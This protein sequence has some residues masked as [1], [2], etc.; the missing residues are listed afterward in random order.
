MD[1]APPPAS[2]STERHTGSFASGDALSLTAM[3]KPLPGTVRTSSS[4]AAFSFSLEGKRK[5]ESAVSDFARVLGVE[6]RRLVIVRVMG[7]GV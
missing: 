2:L 7:D 6:N 5:P 1:F 4:P 3:V